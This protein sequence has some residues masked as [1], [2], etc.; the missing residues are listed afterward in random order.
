MPKPIVQSGNCLSTSSRPLGGTI[1]D[2][3]IRH[4]E[5]WRRYN[6]YGKVRADFGTQ[7]GGSSDVLI[8]IVSA[9]HTEY[10]FKSHLPASPEYS[11]RGVSG[12]KTGSPR[13]GGEW[14]HTRHLIQSSGFSSE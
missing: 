3:R 11:F 8:G 5:H 7:A 10:A 6:Q 9:G 4:K 1:S 14:H 2:R 13:E 12:R